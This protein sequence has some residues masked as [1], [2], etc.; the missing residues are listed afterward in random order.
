MRTLKS[1]IED[2][3]ARRVAVG[4][5]NV[6]DSNQLNAIA[7]VARELAL[8]VIIGVSEGEREW[9]GLHEVVAMVKALR[10]QGQEIYINADH[11]YTVEKVKEAID[12]GCDAVIFDGAKL[13]MEDN[14]AQTRACVEYA[15]GCGR[16]V[17]VEAELGYIGSSSKVLD[18]VPEGAGLDMTT[19]EQ[20]AQFVRETG[21]DLLAPSVGNIHGMLKDVP[22]PALDIVRIEHIA[23]A[24]ESPLVLHGASGNS[25]ED[26]QN[27]IRAGIAIVHINT[28]IRVAYRKGIEQGLAEDDAVAPYKYLG[29]GVEVM[30]EVVTQKLKVFNGLV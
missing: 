8:P 1:V 20:A 4:H 7:S 23:G 18:A 9:V 15:R 30:K 25:E 2:A 6:S 19:P 22:E 12:A 28:E 11:T 21:I 14:I 24:V 17:L 10:D 16:E 5:F 29:K 13:S 27:A 3:C 26:V